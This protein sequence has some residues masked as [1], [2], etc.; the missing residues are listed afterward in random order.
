MANRF[1]IK[2]FLFLTLV[3]WGYDVSSQFLDDFSD[4]NFTSTPV[5]TGST[6]D[7]VVT[8]EMLQLMAAGAGESQLVT[9]S[10]AIE[11]AF[12][13]FLVLMDFGTSESNY[14]KVYLTSDQ[15]DLASSLNGYFVL[16]GRSSDDISLYRQDGE[17]EIV[18]IED[19]GIIAGIDPVNVRIRVTRD[20]DGLWDLSH[21]ITGG[22]TF[23]NVG[24]T[25]DLTH[26]SSQY[27]GIQC[28]YTSTRSEKFFFDGFVVSD[29]EFTDIIPPTIESVNVVSQSKIDVKFNEPLDSESAVNISNFSIDQS[30]SVLNIELDLM[31]RSLVHLTTS[32]FINGQTY[33]LAVSNVADEAGNPVA[34]SL[35]V[36]FRYLSLSDPNFRDIQINEFMANPTPSAG[37]PEVDFVELYNP[38]SN[39]YNLVR[40]QIGDIHSQSGV[41]GNHV[42]EPNGFVIIC[43]NSSI[44]D[45]EVF[46]ATLGVSSFPNFNS[47]NGD[48]VILYDDSGLIVDQVVYT[49]DDL[50]KNGISLEQVNT[51]IGCSGVFN[52]EPSLDEK[53]GTPGLENSVFMIV[54]DNFGPTLVLAYAI[55]D[56][57]LRLDFD[58]ALDPTTVDIDDIVLQ[59][60]AIGSNVHFL[61][62]YPQNLFLKLS[63]ALDANLVYEIGVQGIK[64]C[65]G[66]EVN[67]TTVSFLLGLE[68][69]ENDILLSEVLFNPRAE[70]SDFVEIYNPSTTESFELGGWKLAK[71][72]KGEID[73]ERPIASDGL[74]ISPSQFLV[75]TDDASDIQI[76]YPLGNAEVYIELGGLPSFSNKEGSVILLNK[77]GMVVQQFD[78]LDDYHYELLE[79]VDGVSLERVSYEHQVN[80]PNNWRS[81]SSTVG[82]ASPGRL[83][84][85]SV[86]SR[87]GG[88]QLVVEPKV[89]VPG[90]SGSGRDFATINYSFDQGGKFANVTIYD[91]S[92]RSVKQM[93]NGASLSSSG[94]FRWD[95]TTDSGRMARMG[96]FVIVFDVYDGNGNRSILKETIVVGR[97]F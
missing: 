14:T 95:G 73:D 85:Q 60:S 90:N 12:W 70:G 75:F 22:S 50:G 63:E 47:S 77:E 15:N 52:F 20:I 45:F 93:A 44:P 35:D 62:N 3:A 7:F 13:E 78:Y 54:P 51:D 91:Q 11:E 81:A 82:F 58:E 96:Y 43:A 55:T 56:D 33:T 24:T 6:G 19:D 66:N 48:A 31:N 23:T 53:G 80:D 64:D 8:S 4:G 30:I 97:D 89:I 9:S 79:N 76:Q 26:L 16:I 94:F 41:L 67:E 61:E 32:N 92:G 71:L 65:A 28:I 46:G 36:E 2:A 21:D 40:W 74:L 57:S 86:K 1:I 72:S 18:L 88:G 59:P 87:T 17:D 68:P 84:S 38:T 27:F 10:K 69:Q 5:W 34:V 25:T 39:F 29:T 42:L 37:L 49:G 83:N